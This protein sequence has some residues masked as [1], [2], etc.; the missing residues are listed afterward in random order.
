MSLWK[1]FTIRQKIWS[2]VVVP[3]LV[4]LFFVGRQIHTVNQELESLNKAKS[5]VSFLHNLSQLSDS[6]HDTSETFNNVERANVL[7]S[8]KNEAGSITE[9]DTLDNLH[10]I[11]SQ[12]EELLLALSEAFDQETF[13]D[14]LQWEV[15][16]YQELLLTL[17]KA[18]NARQPS[19]I[20]DQLNALFQLKWMVFWAVKESWLS[21][22]VLTYSRIDE[23]FAAELRKDM[24]TLIQSQQLFVSRYVM[25]NADESQVNLLLNT[26]SDPSFEKTAL[27]REQLLSQSL[28]LSLSENEVLHGRKAMDA[29]LNLFRGVADQISEQL[30]TAAEQ[31]ILGFERNRILLFSIMTLIIGLITSA[32]IAM[33]RNLADKLTLVLE[34]LEHGKKEVPLTQQISG[35]DE[36]SRF[37][38]EVERL[39]DERDLQ[40]QSI[41]KAKEEAERAS[42]AKSSFLANMSH[43]IRTPLNGVIGMS[44]VLASTDLSTTQKDY[45]DTIETSSQ[46]L[47]SL[48]NDILDFSKIES[49][50]LS[51]SENSTSIRETVYDIAAIITPKIKEKSLALNLNIDSGIPAR[52]L[53]DD[54]RIRQILMNLMSNAVKFTR[55]GS[56]TLTVNAE[57][58]SDE[59]VQVYFEVADTGIGISPE[60]QEK[61]F[62]PFAQ[63]D[64]SITKR[65]AGTGLGLAI[66][67]QLIEL[68]GGHIGV[69]SEI[70]RGSKFY[71][72]VELESIEQDYNY[73][74]KPNYSDIVIVSSHEETRNMLSQELTFLGVD[75]LAACSSLAQLDQFPKKHIILYVANQASV[76]ESELS[77]LKSYNAGGSA[78]CHVKHIHSEAFEYDSSITAIVTFPMLGNRLLKALEQCQKAID[79]QH[80]QVVRLRPPAMSNRILCVEDNAINQKVL[81]LQLD[82]EGYEYD[83]ASNGEQAVQLFTGGT[84]YDVVLMDCMMP[85]KDGFTATEEIRQFEQGRQKIPTP[86]IAL[87]ASVLEEDIQRCFDV[88]MNDFISKPFKREV[89]VDVMRKAIA[90]KERRVA[91]SAHNNVTTIQPTTKESANGTEQLSVLLVEDNS[92]NQKV[93]ILL[94]EKAG[95]AYKV[96]NNGQEAI[97]MY[98]LDQTFDVILMDLMMPVK[99]GFAASEAI[100]Q[101]ELRE[102][103]TAT[104][105]IALTASVLN[106]DIQRCFETGMNAYIPKP[107]KAEKLYSE[108]EHLT[109]EHQ[110]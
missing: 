7:M 89:L 30:N 78:V 62:K 22:E 58:L 71:F 20:E 25:I 49:G 77:E 108:I 60:Q 52:V 72:S 105:I 13:A 95:Y 102:S 38:G 53:A 59:R 96:A 33:A 107:I 110:H 61:I 75:A 101:F 6:I 26:F 27:Y 50:K 1:N 100:R 14:N 9:A 106:D 70:E 29:R 67:H 63:A 82:T 109:S 41:V 57:H 69:T 85:V 19:V 3:T 43:E 8:L 99:D 24:Q 47:L 66:S 80:S 88:G 55:H 16:I 73:I 31:E 84:E 32:G 90:V 65:F 28:T 17:E 46:L 56:V 36:L 40:E 94:L 35:S 97:D 37:A 104:P 103:L 5:A 81:S 2:L 21:G 10:S 42:Q 79:N 76:P 74:A 93:A 15:D 4:I 54:H 64:D 68:M 12:Y 34:Y 44:E 45:L 11:L 51:L 86:I 18:S 98:R 91:E 92:I 23:D 39:M 48:I 83:I 87:T